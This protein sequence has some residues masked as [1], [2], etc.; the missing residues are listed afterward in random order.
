MINSIRFRLSASI[1]TTPL[2]VVATLLERQNRQT[3][4]KHFLRAFLDHDE[5]LFADAALVCSM[6][7]V[8]IG[9]IL[10]S[11]DYPFARKPARHRMAE[12]AAARSRGHR[13]TA[14]WQRSPPTQAI[15]IDAVHMRFDPKD[16][17]G[18][19]G[20]GSTP[21]RKRLPAL[22]SLSIPRC[23]GLLVDNEG[24]W[25]ILRCSRSAQWAVAAQ[26]VPVDVPADSN[27]SGSYR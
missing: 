3:G 9:R 7:E 14:Q 11:V 27:G 20:G 19:C 5:R 1:A 6:I 23:A 21:P 22:C 8:D 16:T 4:Q 26:I 24:F 18:L 12:D 15:K 17:Q 13:E 2:R 10:F 25:S